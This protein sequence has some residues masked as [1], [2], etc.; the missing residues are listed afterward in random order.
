LVT[1]ERGTVGKVC[2]TGGV[3]TQKLSTTERCSVVAGFTVAVIRR[4]NA[5]NREF[6]RTVGVLGVNI[7]TSAV[8]RAVRTDGGVLL[9][10]LIEHGRKANTR[11]V[12]IM[13]R[14]AQGLYTR[15]RVPG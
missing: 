12:S 10:G 13:A 14:V 15:E 5:S 11:D 7:V 2:D 1:G 9:F 3:I 4:D 6:T 8:T